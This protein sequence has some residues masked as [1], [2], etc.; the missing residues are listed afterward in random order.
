V[1]TFI[2]IDLAG[3]PKRPTGVCL[4]R[5]RRVETKVVF[6]DDELLD[7]VGSVRPTNVGIDAPLFL[8]LG[9]CCLRNDCT[10]PRTIHFRECDLELRRRGIRF[11]PITLGPMRQLTER[12]IRLREILSKQGYTVLETYPGAAQDLWGIPRQRNIP[13][14]RCGLGQFVEFSRRGLTC[15]ELDAVTCALL[16][17][18]HHQ[19]RTELIGRPDEGWMVLPILKT[20][21]TK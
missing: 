13:G 16:A 12:G 5:G 17:K 7:F 15:H 4:L 18:F 10:C 1:T 2:G 19:G 14:L 8:P 11:F 6:P 21:E 20:A 9:R 3:S